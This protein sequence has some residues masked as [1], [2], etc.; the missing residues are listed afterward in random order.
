MVDDITDAFTG[1]TPFHYG[2]TISDSIDMPVNFGIQF[3][4]AGGAA[5]AVAFLEG[6]CGIYDFG[7]T[8][9]AGQEAIAEFA[10]VMNKAGVNRE[11]REAAYAAGIHVRPTPC[12]AHKVAFFPCQRYNFCNCQQVGVGGG[13][14]GGGGWCR[15]DRAG[16]V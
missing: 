11:V 3:V 4:P 6:V 16:T 1:P 8:F 5:A 7:A 13:G 10:G 15:R 14:G 12:G 2:L 9:T